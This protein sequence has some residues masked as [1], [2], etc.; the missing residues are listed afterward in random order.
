MLC[1]VLSL[2][3]GLFCNLKRTVNLIHDMFRGSS[4]LLQYKHSGNA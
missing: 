4:P 2:L 3:H 1:R